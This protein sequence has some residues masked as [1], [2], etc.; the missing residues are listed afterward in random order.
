M[1]K[2]LGE[3]NIFRKIVLNLL[4]QCEYL[5]LLFWRILPH[6]FEK[7]LLLSAPFYFVI[8]HLCNCLWLNFNISFP[9]CASTFCFFFCS[10]CILDFCVLH[11][12]HFSVFFYC[13]WPASFE[14]FIE[15]IKFFATAKNVCTF[16]DNQIEEILGR[17]CWF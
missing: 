2:L 8:A 14:K 4:Y 15:F 11:F 10:N 3:Q 9:F 6:S 5:C 1:L 13:F 16:L 7:S 17:Q 12:R